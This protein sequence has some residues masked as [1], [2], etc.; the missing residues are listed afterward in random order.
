MHLIGSF[1]D[2]QNELVKEYVALEKRLT[3][4]NATGADAE[5]TRPT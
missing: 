3:A 5:A 2:Q 1:G 4:E